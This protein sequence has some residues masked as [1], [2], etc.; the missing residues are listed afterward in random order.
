[1]NRELVLTMLALDVKVGDNNA[2]YTWTYEGKPYTF[3]AGEIL[4]KQTAIKWHK[5]E[6][7]AKQLMKEM[8]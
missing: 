1:M 6:I 2:E 5:T 8:Q 7:E 4:K 3:S